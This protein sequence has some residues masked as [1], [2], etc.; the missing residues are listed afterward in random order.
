MRELQSSRNLPSYEGIN[1]HS[2]ARS[3]WDF[4]DTSNYLKYALCQIELD[5]QTA[6]TGMYDKQGSIAA[7]SMPDIWRPLREM[8]ENL[9][10]HLH[11]EKID[12]TNRDR[13]QCLW[14]V[15]AKDIHVDIDDLSSGEKAIVQLF[16]PL[17]EH[18]IQALIDNSR[19]ASDVSL[20][21][22][23]TEHVCVLMDEPEL[24][25]HPNLQGKL[26]DYMRSLA[27]RE[28][29]QFIMA[30]HS[31][32]IVESA[33]CDELFL[34]RP[35]EKLS[36]G[37][38]QLTRVASSD[39]KLALLRR[40]FGSMSNLTA[41]RTILV[42]EGRKADADSRRAEDEKIYGLLSHRFAQLTVLAG[43]GKAECKVLAQSLAEILSEELSTRVGAYAL[44]DRDLDSGGSGDSYV[45]RLPVSMV[46]N[47][48]VDPEVIWNAI[49]TVRHKTDFAE[50]ASVED[51]LDAVLGKQKSHEVAR[52]VK[53]KIGRHSFRLRDPIDT[54]GDQAKEHIV[55]V[56]RATSESRLAEIWAE[57]EAD[58]RKLRDE[59]GRREN[60]DGK[61]VLEQFYRTYLHKTGMSKEIFVYECARAGAD[62]KL[63]RHFVDELFKELNL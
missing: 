60:Y 11:F 6:I 32:T 22:T 26:L 61:R 2:T 49:R 63:V 51:A 27:V 58:V 14:S 21:T 28:R 59:N 44:V 40:V 15:H 55:A 54:A 50:V 3:A 30:T 52:R 53:A 42:V 45:K 29:V 5:R 43:G 36:A 25:L 7:D 18:R 23:Q 31:P 13:I 4:D 34:L 39:E 41:L 20:E 9:L 12:V 47:L 1:I 10:P 16:F 8:A 24:H 19:G 35:A 17:I 37:E 48:L 56:E 57:C 33:G 62:R 46:E 38:N